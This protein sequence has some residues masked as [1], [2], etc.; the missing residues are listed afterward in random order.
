MNIQKLFFSMAVPLSLLASPAIAQDEEI[1]ID[2]LDQEDA[3]PEQVTSEI[4]LPDA[5]SDQ[6][7]ESAAEGL[8]TANEARDKHRE[9]GQDRAREAREQRGS[10]RSGGR[11]GSPG[12]GPPGKP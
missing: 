2:V 6:A 3:L 10:D 7:R 9:F 5:A 12:G 1:T 8:D 11:P 4:R